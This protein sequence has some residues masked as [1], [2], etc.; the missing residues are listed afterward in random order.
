MN[1]EVLASIAMQLLTSDKVELAG[2]RLS[3]PPHRPAAT[4][5]YFVQHRGPRV[6]G[7][8]A[9]PRESQLLRPACEKGHAVVQFRDVKENQ[10][11][12]GRRGRKGQ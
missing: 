4:Q 12:C 5:I 8:R 1:T 7:Y 11:H 10:I 9:E 2:E 3:I 6:Y